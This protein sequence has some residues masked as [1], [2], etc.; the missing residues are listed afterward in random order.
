[1]DCG[2]LRI[3]PHLSGGKSKTL[4]GSLVNLLR[5]HCC[6][7]QVRNFQEERRASRGEMVCKQKLQALICRRVPLIDFGNGTK[8]FHTL[9]WRHTHTHTYTYNYRRIHINIYIYIYTY[10][11]TVTLVSL[12]PCSCQMFKNLLLSKGRL[13]CP[14]KGEMWK[15]SLVTNLELLWCPNFGVIFGPQPWMPE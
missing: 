7:W 3:Q 9:T 14:R 15:V 13:R 10:R 6:T 12:L 1:M 5:G 8:P 2:T 11:Y 4:I